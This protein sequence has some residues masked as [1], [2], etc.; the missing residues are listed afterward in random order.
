MVWTLGEEERHIMEDVK[1]TCVKEDC[2]SWKENGNKCPHYM[3]TVWVNESNGV[4]KILEDCAPRR[5]V[6]MLMDMHNQLA[7]IKIYASQTRSRLDKLCDDSREFMTVH[8]GE[9]RNIEN[10]VKSIETVS[11]K[12]VK[13]LL[14]AKILAKKIEVK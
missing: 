4:P 11:K 8:S 14:E 5:T 3:E 9:Q 12:L 1:G 6:L 13:N 7:G 2:Q 10:R